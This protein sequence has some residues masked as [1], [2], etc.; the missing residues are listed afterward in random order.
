M[1]SAA[2]L[3]YF[4][5]SDCAVQA[6]AVSVQ[7]IKVSYT[8][9]YYTAANELACGFIFV[10][11][12]GVPGLG[13]KEPQNPQASDSS[14]PFQCTARSHEKKTWA[15]LI[16]FFSFSIKIKLKSCSVTFWVGF[17]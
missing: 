6:Y 1:F 14:Q 7:E 17:F 2:V 13:G 4:Q 16:I 5:T 9:L 15:E 10:L 11:F 3:I 12:F 8:D